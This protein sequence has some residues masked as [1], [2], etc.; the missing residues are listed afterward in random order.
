M[1][2]AIV[3]TGTGVGKTTL[4]VAWIRRLRERRLRVAGWKPIETGG[5]AD[6]RALA[7]ACG[8]SL[9]AMHGFERPVS[10]HLEARR[11]RAR[12]DPRAIAGR[13]RELGVGRD[14]LLVELAGGLFTPI[15]D[16]GGTNAEIVRAI[17]PQRTVLVAPNRL[18]VL[19]DV[20]A[21]R[22]AVAASGLRIDACVLAETTMDT[23]D[24]SRASNA[25][26]LR[27][28]TRIPVIS[29]DFRS[30][31]EPLSALDGWFVSGRPR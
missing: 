7:S 25:E 26:E 24:E 4:T 28:L 14:S 13:A 10:P 9:E 1:I 17:E 30:D 21:V 12:I 27:R 18:G 31:T 23:E 22:R 11:N 19:H 16:D 3:G 8:E 2:V 20:E 15:D 5:D 29:S 6:R